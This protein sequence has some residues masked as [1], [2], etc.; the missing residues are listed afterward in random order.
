MTPFLGRDIKYTQDPVNTRSLEVSLWNS[1][2]SEGGGLFS[3]K[4]S[5]KRETLQYKSQLSDIEPQWT[6]MNVNERHEFQLKN[7]GLFFSPE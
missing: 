5:K 7:V 6:S 3:W 2:R 1:S 4:K